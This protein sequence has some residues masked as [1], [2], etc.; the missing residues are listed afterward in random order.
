MHHKAK[1]FYR[2]QTSQG[3]KKLNGPPER[4][5]VGKECTGVDGVMDYAHDNTKNLS[6]TCCSVNDFNNYYRKVKESQH[7]F[8]MKPISSFQKHHNTYAGIAEESTLM[9]QQHYS[10]VHAGELTIHFML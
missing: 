6:W 1:Y 2:S 8:C 4:S 5:I 10:M 7:R 9:D 3:I